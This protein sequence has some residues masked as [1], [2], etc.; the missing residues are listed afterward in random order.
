MN[1]ATVM[2]HSFSPS[3]IYLL[4]TGDQAHDK[5]WGHKGEFQTISES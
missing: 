3:E 2:E 1:N 5:S 4:S